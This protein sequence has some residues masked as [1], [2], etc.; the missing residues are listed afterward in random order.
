MKNIALLIA[1]IITF[2]FASCGEEKKKKRKRKKADPCECLKEKAGEESAACKELQAEWAKKA[3]DAKT[4]ED[5]QKVMDAAVATTK[6]C[7]GNSYGQ[8]H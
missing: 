4:P 6:D 1:V 5:K 3:T 7:N 8:T 2:G